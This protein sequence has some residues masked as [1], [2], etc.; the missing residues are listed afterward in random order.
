MAH[1]W[2]ATRRIGWP[3][4]SIT[5][6]PRARSAQVQAESSRSGGEWAR[7]LEMVRGAAADLAH[8]ERLAQEDI[9]LARQAE[10]EIQEAARTL[11][12]ARAY[13]SMGVTLS[14][15]GADSQ[16]AEADRLYRSQNYEQAIRTA[17]A[18]IQ[19]IR[20][21]YA[22][23]AQQVFVRQM[24]V[25]SNRR[26]MSTPS[27]GGPLFVVGDTLSA[28]G[29]SRTSQVSSAQADARRHADRIGDRGR[30]MV[31]R[32][33]RARVVIFAIAT[34]T[35]KKR[36]RCTRIAMSIGVSSWT[37]IQVNHDSGKNLEGPRG[38]VQQ[39]GQLVQ[40]L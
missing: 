8:S 24:T 1:S 10:S 30:L 14:T 27:L 39:A 35:W 34:V 2:P 13:F 19:Q 28:G 9:R 20:Q 29:D 17:A 15:V 37:R 38:P 3:P 7:W 5:R 12:K 4:T 40:R 25:N 18:A 32:N 6:T 26:R 36:E 16:V 23:A 11:R 33:G 21:A 22:V 31:E